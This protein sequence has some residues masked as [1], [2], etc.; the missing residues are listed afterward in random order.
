MRGILDYGMSTHCGEQD[1]VSSPLGELLVG[2]EGLGHQGPEGSSHRS[3][4]VYM[5]RLPIILNQQ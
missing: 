1:F 5:I 3:N 4:Y 2:V